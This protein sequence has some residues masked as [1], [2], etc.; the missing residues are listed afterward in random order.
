MQRNGRSAMAP[1]GGLDIFYWRQSRK[2]SQIFGLDLTGKAV[3]L[4]RTERK[5]KV[6]RLET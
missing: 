5:K 3:S 2:A 1:Q 6:Q 4:P